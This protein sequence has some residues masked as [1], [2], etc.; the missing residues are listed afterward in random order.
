[1]VRMFS[2]CSPSPECDKVLSEYDGL[3]EEHRLG[4]AALIIPQDVL[5]IGL[6]YQLAGENELARD[7]LELAEMDR[8]TKQ[9]ASR[10]LRELPS[11]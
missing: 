7:H 3:L 9:R 5:A 8:K 6:C 10:A 11:E 4:L 1:M 2:R